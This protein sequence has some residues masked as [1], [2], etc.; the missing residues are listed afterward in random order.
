MEPLR[1][2]NHDDAHDRRPSSQKNGIAA[3][4]IT[5]SVRTSNAPR[6]SKPNQR[7]T[8]QLRLGQG[9]VS[10]TFAPGNYSIRATLKYAAC[11]MFHQLDKRI[12]ET[13]QPKALT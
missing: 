5:F 9:P 1:H 10:Q 4:V 11:K 3:S 2:A 6:K 13:S 12:Q 7:R 8:G